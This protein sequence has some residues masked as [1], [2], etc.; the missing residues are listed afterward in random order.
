MFWQ[1][2]Q[3]VIVA[4][5]YE[6]ERGFFVSFNE[7]WQGYGFPMRKRRP[8]DYDEAF[9]AREALREAVGLRLPRAEARPLEYVAYRGAS[10][11]TGRETLYLY[12]AYEVDPNERLPAGGLGSRH[13]F[14]SC[15]DLVT[16]DLVTWSTKV[17][18]KELMEN[19]EVALAVICRR[20]AGGRE[21]LMVRSARYGGYFFPA[22]RLKTDSRPTWE[23]VE[24]VRRETG[25]FAPMKCGTPRAV[26]DVHVSPR[27]G[28]PRRYVFHIVPVLLPAVDL[29][30]AP[31]R[32]EEGL[33]R[34]E[35]LWRWVGEAELADP[36]GN[37]LSPTV[38]AV[39]DAAVRSCDPSAGP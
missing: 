12:Q 28:C 38:V 11:R 26:E 15:E 39:V 37:D 17:I 6:P 34:T 20:G 13:G 16:A 30:A 27:F 25:Y 2:M 10:G 29:S 3:A 31:N 33:G 4:V 19:Q 24:A 5:V 14:L 1:R 21:F 36:A 18:V 7:K 22:S 23:A 35:A 32:L 8:T 9:T